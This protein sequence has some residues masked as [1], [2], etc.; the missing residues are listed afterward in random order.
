MKKILIFFILFIIPLKTSAY[1]C[2]YDDYNMARKQ[3]NNV[4]YFVDYKI[5]ND[6]AIFTITIYNIRNNQTIKD[7]KNNKSYSYNGK[8]YIKIDVTTSGM[9]TFE[10]YSS[11]NYCDENYLNK[12]FVEIPKYNKYYKDDLCKGIENFK[13]CQKW[14]STDIS[15]SDFKKAITEY[16]DKKVEIEENEIDD[17][18]SIYEYIL[19]FY[20]DY[21]FIIL[22]III[23][24]CLIG[25]AIKKKKENEFNL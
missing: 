7:V 18:K 2:N 12:L 11:E 3:A 22:P 25:I 9:Y 13:Y 24:I 8:E 19:E 10:V 6:K 23:V 5:E 20:L 21:Y 1:Y 17:Y 4:N 14:F 16:K 15:Y